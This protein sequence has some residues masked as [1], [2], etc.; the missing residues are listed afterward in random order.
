MKKIK[1]ANN[2][3]FHRTSK[4]HTFQRYRSFKAKLADAVNNMLRKGFVRKIK[5]VF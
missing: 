1:T 4:L 3:K 2:C 5:S